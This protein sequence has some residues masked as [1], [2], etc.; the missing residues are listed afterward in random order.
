V[1]REDRVDLRAQI[2]YETKRALKEADTTIWE[3]VDEAVRTHFGL[4]ETST[5]AALKAELESIEE[6]QEDIRDQMAVLKDQ[7]ETLDE[8]KAHYESELE[9]VRERRQSY[10]DG[11]DELLDEMLDQPEKTVLAW[12]SKLKDLAQ[13]EYGTGTDSNIDAVV[14]DIRERRDER[15][16]AVPDHR[17]QRKTANRV[18]GQSTL[19]A[20]TDGGDTG[21]ELNFGSG[22]TS[23]QSHE[24]RESIPLDIDI[25]DDG[26]EDE[27]ADQSRTHEG[28]TSES[29]PVRADGGTNRTDG[30]LF[31]EHKEE[32]PEEW[33]DAF[34][35]LTAQGKSPTGIKATIE[36]VITPKTQ[37]EVSQEFN[38][39]E[40]TIRNLQA[41]VVALGPV[42]AKRGSS[43]GAEQKT[44]MDYCNHIAD[45]LGWDE[46]IEFSVSDGVYN[47]TPQPAVLK[48]GWRSLYRAIASGS[49]DSKTRDTTSTR[50]DSNGGD[51]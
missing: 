4:D 11:I 20:A 26:D 38:V 51:S 21:P 6:E 10:K 8:R 2:P 22:D 31:A 36:Y 23:D 18:T 5:E 46:D 35:A 13:Q 19:S 45:R 37:Q 25:E 43:H 48:E 50:I 28:D 24:E 40:V 41:A 42:E 34:D 15:H 3:A 12:S 30:E 1:N 27:M 39:S 14:A 17:F 32:L 47:S 33:H 49:K 16:L 7:L 29:P 9:N 44:A